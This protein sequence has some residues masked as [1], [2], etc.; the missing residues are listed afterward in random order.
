MGV[1][2]GLRRFH[3][4]IGWLAGVPLL[5][6]TVSGLWMAARPI[7]EVRGTDRRAPPPAF[8]LPGSAALPDAGGRALSGLALEARPDGAIWVARFADGSAR[9][10]DPATGGWL[11]PLD[12]TEARAAARA[13]YL[14]PA[15]IAGA[16]L[17]PASAPPLDLRQA[18][19][20]W[21]V[22][23]SDGA[24]VY[25]DAE[26][27]G[28]LA[29]RTRQWRAFDWMWGLHIMDLQGRSATHHPLLIGFAAI[30]VIACLVG[31]VLMPLAVRRRRR[32]EG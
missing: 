15:A 3:I 11:G 6:W 23:F 8:V 32:R 4:W 2:S 19:P 10:A 7:E 9:R 18:R 27:G 24:N 31:I 29:V 13:A 30:A 16:S 5:F 1:R 12:E 21:G 22:A 20:A 28:V 14:P 26:T 25:I 17:T